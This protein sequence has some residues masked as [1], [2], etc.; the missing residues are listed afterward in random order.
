MTLRTLP[1]VTVVGG[2][3]GGF[4]T[5]LAL[6]RRGM[7]VTVLERAPE[8]KE[9]GAGLQLA[10]N[11]GKILK[12]LGVYDAVLATAVRP[13]RFAIVDV[14]SGTELYQTALGDA[15]SRRFGAPYVVLHRHDLLTAL[16]EAAKATGRVEAI[17]G[18][19]VV[20]LAQDAGGVH[21]T[22]AD[23]TSHRSDVLLGADGLRSVVR[24]HIL[25]ES[26][27]LTSDYVIYRGPGPRTEDIEDAVMLYT[28]HGMHM[29][30]YPMQGGTMVNRVVSFRSTRGVPG[31][32][33]WGTEEELFERFGGACDHVRRALDS[34]DLE[35]KWVQFDR[36]PQAGWARGRV[37]LLGDAAHAMRQY[38]AQGAGQAMEDAIAVADALSSTP[39]EVAHALA[40]YEA[41]RYPRAT[42]VQMNTRFFGEFTHLGGVEAVVRNYLLKS[43][44]SDD[45]EF[46]EWLYGDQDVAAPVPPK[47]LALY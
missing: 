37:A 1:R 6:A 44:R 36:M 38:L 3:I 26:D 43:M 4:T 23:G 35:K 41:A 7:D 25:D 46:V 20:D 27:P 2:G 18:K 33:E 9:I 14:Y 31:S 16:M 11:A 24:R 40:S 30:Q 29:M 13:R 28:G 45:Y 32:D 17:S 19:E 8:F 10:P 47:A 22:C 34:L 12:G 15:L 5:A 39:D 42:A 21:V